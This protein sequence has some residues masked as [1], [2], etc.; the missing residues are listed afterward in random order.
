MLQQ[1]YAEFEFYVGVVLKMILLY[2]Q[3]HNSKN[4]KMVLR[5]MQRHNSKNLKMVLCYM[6]TLYTVSRF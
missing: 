1:Q 4:L 6:Q 5:Y 3:I 2:M